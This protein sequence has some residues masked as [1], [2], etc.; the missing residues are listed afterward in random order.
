MFR[1]APEGVFRTASALYGGTTAD[2][3]LSERLY[4]LYHGNED[5]P[6]GIGGRLGAF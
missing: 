4:E 6:Y 2:V 5:W 1:A 3:R